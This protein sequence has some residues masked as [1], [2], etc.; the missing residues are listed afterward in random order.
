VSDVRGA[1]R[2]GTWAFG[3][4]TMLLFYRSAALDVAVGYGHPEGAR[5]AYLVS[6]TAWAATVLVLPGGDRWLRLL[7]GSAAHSRNGL[8]RWIAAVLIALTLGAA[9]ASTAAVPAAQQHAS[10]SWAVATAGWTLIAVSIGSRTALMLTWL[11]AP[12]AF[13]M[14]AAIEGGSTQIVMMVARILGVLGLQVPVALAAQALERSADTASALWL[15]QDAISTDQLVADTVHEDRLRRSR[16]VATLIEPVLAGLAGSPTATDPPDE[17]VRRRCGVAA[18][19]VRRLLMEWHRGGPDPLGVDLSACL[20]Q[21]Q[22]SGVHVDV[23]VPASLTPTGLPAPLRRVA[24]DVVQRLTGEPVIR[25]RLSIV[26][27]TT[28]LCLAVVAQ[29]QPGTGGRA[30]DLPATVPAPLSIRTTTSGDFFWVELT[31]PL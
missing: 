8:R 13:A 1:L 6:L 17:S 11:A 21:A 14:L 27:T 19:Q 23:A 7:P 30:L 4:L 26:S 9:A 5:V 20:D 12:P 16:A 15:Q 29:A 3:G 25:I 10:A 18:A 2:W 31:C 28:Q 22:E 24:C